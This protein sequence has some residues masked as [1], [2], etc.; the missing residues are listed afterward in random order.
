MGAL[1]SRYS[2]KQ[3]FD[4]WRQ[5]EL[6]G[7]HPVGDD[8]AVMVPAPIYLAKL[9]ATTRLPRMRRIRLFHLG[10]I[11][12]I[13]LIGVAITAAVLL[14]LRLL[15]AIEPLPPD[16]GVVVNP[17]GPDV[18]RNQPNA[19]T[20]SAQPATAFTDDPFIRPTTPP[21]ITATSAILVD[22][23]QRTIL[24]D[25]AAHVPRAPASLAKLATAVV[26]LE[27]APSNTKIQI[28]TTVVDQ[29]PNAIGLRPDEV[30]SLQDL[31]FAMLLPSANDAAVAIADGIGGEA[32]TVALMNGLARRLGLSHTRFANTV[33]YDA[34][35]QESTAFELAAL[36]AHALENSPL[37]AR[38]V[39]TQTYVIPASPT[40]TAYT[41]TNLNGLLW[42]YEGAI[43]IKTG[44]TEE[45]GGNIIAAAERGGQRLMVIIL[46]SEQREADAVLLLDFGFQLLNAQG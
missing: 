24:F 40:N 12:E 46:G 23:S 13:M 9:H 37:I 43:G 14:L 36:A 39:S 26:A 10:R 41:V 44:S 20:A 29:P 45:A 2:S 30:M 27:Q 1:R 31:L 15:S 4:D 11:P 17:L 38:I 8:P 34:P 21:P 5:E 25:R 33:G 3:P 28:P 7:S 16:R 32:Y 18:A 22:L 6:L 19:P 35:E 42:S